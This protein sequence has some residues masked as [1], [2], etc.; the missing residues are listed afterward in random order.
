MSEAESRGGK[1]L[2]WPCTLSLTVRTGPAMTLS[3]LDVY[4]PNGNVAGAAA[5]YYGQVGGEVQV[6]SQYAHV[7]TEIIAGSAIILSV[8]CAAALQNVIIDSHD[9]T[10][11]Y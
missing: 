7:F 6:A 2:L 3:C 11:F 5:I 10:I 1:A 4:I 8:F 9:Q